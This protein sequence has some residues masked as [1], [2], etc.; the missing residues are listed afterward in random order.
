MS[1]YG[2][3]TWMRA[4]ARCCCAV[5]VVARVMHEAGKLGYRGGEA[6]RA[7]RIVEPLAPDV[8]PGPSAWLASAGHAWPALSES[9][10][11]SISSRQALRLCR[12]TQGASMR[13]KMCER[14]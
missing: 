2:R 4:R 3:M 14:T 5:A 12:S 8:V 7:L 6:M 10:S 1:D 11:A 9:V 13:G